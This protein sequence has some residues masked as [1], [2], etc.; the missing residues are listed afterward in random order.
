VHPDERVREIL[1][2]GKRLAREYRD[3]T[4]KPLDVTGE[5][6]EYEAA[7]VLGLTLTPARQA[8]HDAI[9]RSPQRRKSPKRESESASGLK[10]LG[11]EAECANLQLMCTLRRARSSDPAY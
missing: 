11:S 10:R 4:G 2:E 3:L 6:A 7:R 1:D 8:G 5:V 9:E